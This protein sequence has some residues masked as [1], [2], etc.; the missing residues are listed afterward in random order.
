MPLHF[1]IGDRAQRPRG[2]GGPV[3]PVGPQH[4]LLAHKTSAERKEYPVKT[5]VIDYFRD[6]LFRVAKVSYEGNERHNPG[7][8]LHWSRGKSADHG[9]CAARH[10][11][12]NDDEV[13]AAEAAW[14]A[15]AH[16]Q[17]L[18]E[19]KYN[20]APPPGCK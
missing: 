15:L 12:C 19:K 10:M 8:P 20:I 7:Q 14:R 6:A 9:D 5:G 16:L 18:L 13:E 4:D 1:N 17:L 3:G 2:P 11:F